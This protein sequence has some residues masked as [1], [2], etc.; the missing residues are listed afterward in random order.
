MTESVPDAQATFCA[1]LV[2]EWCA[3]GVRA[4]VVAPGSRS[5][6]MALALADRPELAVHV[7]HDERSA[8]FVALGLGLV[9]TP[10][11]LLS[12]SG[13]AAVNFHPAVVEAGASDVPML[14]VTADRPPELRDVGAPQTI[15]QSH[16]FGR[17]R[18]MVPRPGR[19]RRGVSP[20]RGARWPAARS[21]SRPPARSTSICRSATRSS[22]DQARCR[23]VGRRSRPSRV[24]ANGSVR[25]AVS[26]RVRGVILAGGRG[27]VSGGSDRQARRDHALARAG[28]SDVTGPPAG[29][30]DHRLRRA[31][32]S[33]AVRRRTPS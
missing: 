18:A 9:G 8:A 31:A 20:T 25:G 21:T 11:V 32:P 29:P 10:A 26:T 14:V 1:T 16:L 4:A 22:G 33:P 30:R 19:G 13:T 27:G 3:R 24:R 5:T 6:P 28:R 12:T 2:D 23:R 17:V 15:D 7:V